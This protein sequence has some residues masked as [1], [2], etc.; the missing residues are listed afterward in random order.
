[1][2]DR[3][4]D[5]SKRIIWIKPFAQISS[6]VFF[7]LGLFILVFTNSKEQDVYLIPILIA[8]LWSI[9]IFAL[10]SLFPRIP[11]KPDSNDKFFKRVKVRV[12]RGGYHVL[13]VLF[14]ILT[15][16]AIITSYKIFGIWLSEY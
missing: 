4:G 13:G 10:I 1:M 11:S 9:N 5:I 8:F 14:L 16:S 3:L 12:K 2:I 6:I 7:G 15:V